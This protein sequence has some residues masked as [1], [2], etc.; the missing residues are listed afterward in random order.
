MGRISIGCCGF[1]VRRDRY[2]QKFKV[3]EIQQTFYQPPTLATVKRWRE[4]A[5]P[6]FLFTVKAWQ[7]ITH[8]LTSPT[9][10]RLKQPLTDKEKTEA[11]HLQ[12]TDTVLKAWEETAAIADTLNAPVILLQTPSSFRPEEE[13]IERLYRLIPRIRS[14]AWTIAWEPRGN[15]SPNLIETV[16]RELNLLPAG[17]PFGPFRPALLSSPTRYFRLHGVTGYRYRFTDSD[18]SQLSTWLGDTPTAYCLFNNLT[19]WDDALRLQSLLSR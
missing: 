1:P 7:L 9:Y 10:R 5:P 13:N 11:G 4:E 12:L 16:C 18:L 2:Y 8:P 17:D 6:D 19:M 14:P 3:V 15:W